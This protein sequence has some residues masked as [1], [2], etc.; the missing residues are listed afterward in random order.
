[1]RYGISEYNLVIAELL[2]SN[3]LNLSL[4]HDAWLIAA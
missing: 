4:H 2:Q 3:L 1:M